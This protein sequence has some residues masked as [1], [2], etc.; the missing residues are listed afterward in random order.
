MP[1]SG[2]WPTG[3]DGHEPAPAS[4]GHDAGRDHD[5]AAPGALP[6]GPGEGRAGSRGKSAG[7]GGP[8]GP[9]AGAMAP[10][11][12]APGPARAG[13]AGL[14]TPYRIVAGL[15][16]VAVGLLAC[17]HLAMVFLHVAP[18]NTLSKQYGEAV[19]E[20]IYPEFEQN[21]KLFAP[22][23]LQQNISVHVRAEV[24]DANG[25]RR[26]TSWMSLTAEDSEAIRHNPLP[27]H[28]NQNELRRAWDFYVNSHDD[29]NRSTG[30]RGE[31]AEAY[32]RRIVMLRLGKHDHG[33]T[34]D[35]IQLRS[36]S[37]QVP[38]PSWSAEK[39]RTQ[40]LYRELGWWTVSTGDLPEGS[41]AA[42]AASGE[43]ADQ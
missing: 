30:T 24:V 32:L 18:S 39:A 15:V 29:K 3:T 10:A 19:D 40:P 8:G 2:S 23:P 12:A 16:T 43:E 36:S 4:E 11:G 1:P 27:S 33:G 20:W 37:R 14:S 31:L 38:A 41:G 22:N 7:A 5:T 13:I 25:D 9:G 6:P 26:T 35:R 34:V 21:W 42:E 17:T 28:A